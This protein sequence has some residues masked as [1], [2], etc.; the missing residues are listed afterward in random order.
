MFFFFFW[1]LLF[2]I[3]FDYRPSRQSLKFMSLSGFGTPRSGKIKDGHQIV[4]YTADECP[5]PLGV[6]SSGARVNQPSKITP[7]SLCCRENDKTVWTRV[8]RSI[9]RNNNNIYI[10]C[11]PGEL[12]WG[13]PA[14][15]PPPLGAKSQTCKKKKKR[16]VLCMLTR[17]Y[18]VQCI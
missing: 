4:Y 12:P 3:I 8:E 6:R 2:V 17:R 18:R 9:V 7:E 5:A 16:F 10:T 11:T 13:F 14:R 15:E 1:T